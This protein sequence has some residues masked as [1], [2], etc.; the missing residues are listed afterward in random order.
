[1]H[2]S[3]QLDKAMCI[4][5]KLWLGIVE[6]GEREDSSRYSDGR[7]VSLPHTLCVFVAHRNDLGSTHS[8]EALLKQRV[9][10]WP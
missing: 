5:L 3:C 6:T 10:G 4:A 2:P 9:C 8:G 1:M 7:Q